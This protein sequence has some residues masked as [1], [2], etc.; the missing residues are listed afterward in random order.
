MR[1]EYR[2]DVDTDIIYKKI[3]DAWVPID[4]PSPSRAMDL[5]QPAFRAALMCRV[6]ALEALFGRRPFSL[7]AVCWKRNLTE[8]VSRW[9]TGHE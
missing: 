2:R 7:W 5:A 1:A 4:D 9:A 6:P 3:G 8:A